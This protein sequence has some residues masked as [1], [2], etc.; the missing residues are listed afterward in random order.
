[1]TQNIYDDPDFFTGYSRLERSRI[2]LDGMAEWP[3]L[4]AMLPAMT[5]KRVVDLGCG[6][7]WFCRWAQGAG[8]RKI[9]GTDVS[10][11]MLARART[12]AGQDRITYERADLETLVLPEAAFDLAYSSL[13]FH[14]VEDL[15]R[16]FAT[17]HRALVPGG[18]FVFSIEHPIY[19]A[20][21]HPGWRTDDQ[22]HKF[23]PLDAYLLEGPRITDWLAPGVVKQHR[24]MGTTLTLLIQSG[25]VL[26]HVE[27]W[28]PSDQ[29][30]AQR[31]EL[32]EELER[33][34]FLLVAAGR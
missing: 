34:M 24:T 2:G 7:G 10:E 11:M 16:L 19:M 14:Y 30:I 13:A 23:W 26:K 28:R 8:A 3:A 32:A 5:G 18:Q 1:M 29:Q 15:A 31:P 9:L 20:P 12:E 22:G 25:F 4:Q 33:P 27:D 17:V 6:Y 21:R